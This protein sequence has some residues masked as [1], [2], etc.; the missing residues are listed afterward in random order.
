MLITIDLV[1]VIEPFSLPTD[2]EAEILNLVEDNFTSLINRIVPYQYIGRIT[3]NGKRELYYYVETP[4]DI[5]EKLNELI[6]QNTYTREF[7]YDISQDTGWENVSYFF[8]Y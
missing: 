6:E 4:Q 5:H 3:D 2:K 7:Q 1:D 8:N